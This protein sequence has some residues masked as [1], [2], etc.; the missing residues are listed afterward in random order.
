MK[1]SSILAVA[2]PHLLKGDSNRSPHLR[3][4]IVLLILFAGSLVSTQVYAQQ[5]Q[6]SGTVLD[7]TKLPVIGA[8]VKV[9]GGTV[10][11]AADVNGKF[12][13]EVPNDNAIL[14]I[15]S[16]GFVTKEVTVGT[17]TSINV[18]LADESRNLNTVVVVG[19]GTQKKG[20]I[21]S[22]TG[23]ADTSDFRQSGSRNPLDLIQ[24]KIAGLQITRA[25]GTN[26]NSGVNIQ[27]RGVT[28]VNGTNT[29]LIVIDGIP[30]GRLDL[31]QQDDIE[32]IDVLKD[33]SGAA[34]YGTSANAGVILV[35]TKKAKEGP[36]QFT[37]SSYVRKEYLSRKPDFLTADEF[38]QKIKEGAI[39]ATDYGHSSDF[40]MT[41][42]T[43]VTCRKTITF[44]YRVVQAK[45][46]TG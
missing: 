19:Y 7:Q 1:N 24:G 37:Y 40:L 6:V 30:G 41:W 31:L 11:V 42:L 35:T 17:Q 29:P 15:S 23:H 20:E 26:P 4:V 32:S 38:R 44:R 46:V 2:P 10:G 8:S 34:I 39:N 33:G 27:L 5:K 13:I 25:G 22:A 14:V 12:I 18:T 9:K 36:A 3:K 28:S 43:K 45:P 21:T 16:L